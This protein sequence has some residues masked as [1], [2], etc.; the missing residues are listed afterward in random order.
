MCSVLHA[1]Q[2][3]DTALPH[4]RTHNEDD[5]LAWCS[6]FQQGSSCGVVANTDSISASE[7]RAFERAHALLEIVHG[8]ILDVYLSIH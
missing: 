5:G 1:Y 3:S 7:V 8:F 6:R 4:R 2:N